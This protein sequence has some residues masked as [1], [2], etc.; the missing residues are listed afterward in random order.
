MSKKRDRKLKELAKTG[1]VKEAEPTVQQISAKPMCTALSLL[2]A[3]LNAKHTAD[4]FSAVSTLVTF[5]GECI[6]NV[7]S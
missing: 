3:H 4:F 6:E 7:S 1:R 5:N 2:C